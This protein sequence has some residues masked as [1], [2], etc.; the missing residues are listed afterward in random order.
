MGGEKHTD[1]PDGP[2]FVPDKTRTAFLDVA[3]GLAAILVVYT[4]IYDVFIRDHK[5]VRTPPTDALDTTLVIPLKL[6]EQGIGA[7]SVPLFFI[8]SGFV[9]TPIAMRMGPRRFGLNRTFRIY[10]LLL[11][12]VT[13]SAVLIASGRSLLSTRP[14]EVTVGSFLSNAT[15]WNFIDRPFGAWV[16]VAW[17][18]AVEILFYAMLVAV[19]PLLR[20][21]VWLA[22]SV[23]LWFVLMLLI[24]YRAFG[25]EYRAFVINMT[26]TLIPLLGQIIWAVWNRKI[27]AWLAG[28]FVTAAWLMFVWAGHLRIDPDYI[29]RPFPIAFAMMLFLIGLLAEPYLRQRRF[30]TE[31]SERTYSIYLLHGAVAFPLMHL[32]FTKLP[33]WLTVLVAVLATALVAELAYRFVERPSHDLA[34]RL[35][36]RHRTPAPDRT[37]EPAEAEPEPEPEPVTP[38]PADAPTEK[39]PPVARPRRRPT[40]AEPGTERI[41]PVARPRTPEDHPPE[42]A[43]APPRTPAPTADPVP[44]SPTPAFPA[45]ASPS[46]GSGGLLPPRP[47]VALPLPAGRRRAAELIAARDRGAIPPTNGHPRPDDSTDIRP[48]GPDDHPRRRPTGLPRRAEPAGHPPPGEP[49]GPADARPPM[50]EHEAPRDPGRHT[51]PTN[52]RPPTNDHDDPRDLGGPDRFTSPAN[53]RP[54]PTPDGHED[55][56][57]RTGPAN[58]RSP[59]N[60]HDNPRDSAGPDRFTGRPRPTTNGHSHTDP[61]DGR[62]LPAPNGRPGTGG[63]EPAGDAGPPVPRNGRR[64]AGAPGTEGAAAPRSGGGRRRLAEPTAEPAAEGGGRRRLAEPAGVAPG[65]DRQ[66]VGRGDDAPRRAGTVAEGRRRAEERG[67]RRAADILNAAGVD[68]AGGGGRRRAEDRV[69]AEPVP[70]GT[71]DRAGSAAAVAWPEPEPGSDGA[72]ARPRRGAERDGGG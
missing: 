14:P 46:T 38:D 66:Q 71:T 9:V 72:V 32:L 67:R 34:R 42:S 47:A 41:V 27:P 58:L 19:L 40:P 17:T 54:R 53:G 10:P 48:P 7:I 2:E 4:H 28:L 24:T 25:D 69:A 29:P 44:A 70:F 3:R 11:F 60:D 49:A 1:R 6:D 26:Y 16:A 39:T 37:E 65:G 43:P 63:V 8:I 59:T 45:A 22:I 15:L 20:R 50:N 56:R 61:A 33:L 36:R 64:R 57:A 12:V 62:P 51:G 5:D 18:L 21:R 35:S 30:W 55:S 23:Q 13:L 31:L 52:L 68:G